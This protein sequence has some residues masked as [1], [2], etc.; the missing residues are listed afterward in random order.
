MNKLVCKAK[1]KAQEMK[2]AIMTSD[3]GG[4]EIIVELCLTVV[5]VALIVV[6]REN[7]KTLVDGIMSEAT[8][9]ITGLF[10]FV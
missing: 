9:T 10:N 7:I 2:A 4:K 3:K 8:T 6:F 1:N 5:A